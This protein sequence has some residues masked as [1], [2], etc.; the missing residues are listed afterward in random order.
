MTPQEFKNSI[1]S[2]PIIQDF[3]DFLSYFQQNQVLLTTAGYLGPKDCFALNDGMYYKEIGVTPKTRLVKYPLLILFIELAN[4]GNFLEIV[5]IKSKR[6]FQCNHELISVYN[7]MNSAEKYLH[8]LKLLIV[9]SNFEN[10]HNDEHRTPKSMDV[11]RLFDLAF[12]VKSDSAF[13]F[14]SCPILAICF[15]YFGWAEVKTHEEYKDVIKDIEFTD[16]G[17][18]LLGIVHKHRQPI[19]WNQYYYEIQAYGFWVGILFE[20]IEMTQEEFTA[21][22]NAV[23]SEDFEIPFME[24]LPQGTLNLQIPS[25]RIEREGYYTFKVQ[26]KRDPKIWRRIGI[27]GDNSLG[28]LHLAVQKAYKFDNDHLYAFYPTGNTRSEYQFVHEYGSDGVFA[29]SAKIQDIALKDGQNMLYIFDFG[30]YWE[31]DVILE[32]VTP[33]KGQKKYKILEKEGKAPKQYNDWW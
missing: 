30:D 27:E 9:E 32:S 26:L 6:G 17:K 13:M 10:I 28:D 3:D 23:L 19:F 14:F 2:Q 20:E 22:E 4:A 25:Q 16:F 31:F 12:R 7:S 8:L 29:T 11:Q 33:T 15:E 5:P 24:Q 21:R 1:T 18:Y